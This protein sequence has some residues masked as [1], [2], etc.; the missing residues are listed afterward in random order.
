MKTGIVKDWRYMEHDMGAFHV[1][2]PRRIEAIYRMVEK[3]ISFPYAEIEP[4]P[5]EEKEIQMVHTSSYIETIKETSGIR[6]SSAR[7]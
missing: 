7:P 5:A 4:R 3:D 2:N 6:K 1:E